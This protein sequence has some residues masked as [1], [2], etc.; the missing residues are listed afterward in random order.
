MGMNKDGKLYTLSGHASF[1]KKN[2]NKINIIMKFT[3]NSISIILMN[4]FR[5][6]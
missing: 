5:F 6:N 3:Q 2:R 4:K 1:Q